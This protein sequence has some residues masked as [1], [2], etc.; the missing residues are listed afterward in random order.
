MLELW[1][2]RNQERHGKDS[3]SRR[4]QEKALTMTE[5]DEVYSWKPLIPEEWQHLYRYSLDEIKNKPISI[6]R[7]WINSYK[8]ILEEINEDRMRV[9]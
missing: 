4:R 1:D 8:P 7:A 9:R 6:M 2:L 3:E 5:L